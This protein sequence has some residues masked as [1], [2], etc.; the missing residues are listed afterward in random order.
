MASKQDFKDYLAGASLTFGII[1]LMF[2]VI[3]EFIGASGRK[4][5]LSDPLMFAVYLLPHILG[6][7]IATYLVARRRKTNLLRAG[8][9]TVLLAY[10]LES[11]YYMIFGNV[12]S[13][14]WSLL[15]LVV[16]GFLGSIL[17]GLYR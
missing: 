17:S 11:I 8:M 6:G 5:G 14:I 3:S 15:A 1:I 12:L 9:M 4:V 13:D 7:T 10:A 16:G 2:Q